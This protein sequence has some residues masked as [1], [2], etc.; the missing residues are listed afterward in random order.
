MGSSGRGGVGLCRS[1]RVVVFIVTITII[2]IIT[3]I[4]MVIVDDVVV[5]VVD[6]GVFCVA[7]TN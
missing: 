5:V 6:A 3:I 4:I 2:I 1:F 7:H